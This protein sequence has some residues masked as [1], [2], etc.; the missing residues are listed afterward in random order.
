MKKI[1]IDALASAVME[2]LDQYAKHST[3]EIKQIVEEVAK[4]TKEEIQANAP[5]KSGKYAK[6]WAV[7]KLN[8]N[9]TRLNVVV[10]SRNKYQLTHLLEF[11]HAKRNGGRVSARPH[12]EQA[13]QNAVKLMEEKIQE[14]LENG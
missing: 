13:E 6:S 1:G 12:I 8:E 2:E 9:S 14:V 5:Q 3:K 7:K 10:H 4:T 11:G